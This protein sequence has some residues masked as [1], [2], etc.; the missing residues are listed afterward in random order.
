MALLTRLRERLTAL[1][2]PSARQRR[3]A[4]PA[5]IYTV[6]E[7]ADLGT[8]AGALSRRG[9]G[10]TTAVYRQLSE[11]RALGSPAL[12]VHVVTDSRPCR[13]VLE[14]WD[15]R[16]VA[17]SGSGWTLMAGAHADAARPAFVVPEP[18]RR[19]RLYESAP[20]RPVFA[21][22]MRHAGETEL[23][24]F[25]PPYVTHITIVGGGQTV[26]TAQRLLHEQGKHVFHLG[27]RAA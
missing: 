11:L 22:S 4:P 18:L 10:G 12:F 8:T 2:R 7:D 19:H 16:H 3:G 17:F 20:A 24:G 5:A 9:A 6:R 14:R 15:R 13:L 1:V 27:G 21:V 23:R 25:F 26:V